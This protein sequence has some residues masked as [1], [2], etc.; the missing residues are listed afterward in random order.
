MVWIERSDT[1]LQGAVEEG[2]EIR[3]VVEISFFDFIET[4]HPST[5]KQESTVGDGTHLTPEI[6]EYNLIPGIRR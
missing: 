1:G 6:Q 4:G 5:H 2:G 3:E